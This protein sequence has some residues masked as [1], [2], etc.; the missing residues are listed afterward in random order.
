MRLNKLVLD[1]MVQGIGDHTAV[2]ELL[3]VNPDR[4]NIWEEAV[5]RR[6]Q[7][8]RFCYFAAK[9]PKLASTFKKTR[10][11]VKNNL[12]TS[13]LGLRFDTPNFFAATLNKS[14]SDYKGE[15]VLNIEWGEDKIVEFKESKKIFFNCEPLIRIHYS[16]SEGD[17]WLTS[18]DSWDFQKNEGA[19]LLTF[20]ESIVKNDDLESQ[21]K[22]ANSISK[23][24]LMPM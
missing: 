17:G 24:V 5:I 18:N 6:E 2:W 12:H 14:F 16:Y 3:L 11:F 8:N 9:W 10:A 13:E 4:E 7:L 1:E 15:L 21:I 19:V 20:I 23:I 22:L